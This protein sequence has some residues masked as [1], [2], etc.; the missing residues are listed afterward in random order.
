M[1]KIADKEPYLNYSVGP[2]LSHFDSDF[3][4]ASGTF[5][6]TLHQFFMMNIQ[7]EYGRRYGHQDRDAPP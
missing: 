7:G 3:A 1:V 5:R 2:G 4:S 6:E